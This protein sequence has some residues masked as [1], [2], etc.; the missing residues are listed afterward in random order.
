MAPRSGASLI[1]IDLDPLF[2]STSLRSFRCDVTITSSAAAGREPSGWPM[3]PEFMSLA[4]SEVVGSDA[5]FVNELGPGPAVMS[6]TGPHSFFGPTTSTSLGCVGGTA[7]GTTLGDPE[8]SLVWFTGDGSYV[9]SN[10]RSVHH[11][12]ASLGWDC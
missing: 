9:F 5:T 6:F 11:T 7:L 4:L 10:P 2:G 8:R 12:A 3:S 1:Q